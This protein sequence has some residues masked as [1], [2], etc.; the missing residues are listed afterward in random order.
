METEGM[1]GVNCW[2]LGLH[3]PDL[4][5]VRLELLPCQ[6]IEHQGLDGARSYMTFQDKVLDTVRHGGAFA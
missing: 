6:A 4:V 3:Q 5:Q 2:L 1:E